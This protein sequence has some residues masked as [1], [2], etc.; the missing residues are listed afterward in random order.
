MEATL[1]GDI[2]KGGQRNP[3]ALRYP[4]SDHARAFFKRSGR[5]TWSS[6]NF[7]APHCSSNGQVRRPPQRVTRSRSSSFRF[8]EQLRNESGRRYL[9]I[10][11]Q[12]MFELNPDQMKEVVQ[13]PSLAK[14]LDLMRAGMM[15]VPANLVEDRIRERYFSS[16]Q[17][18]PC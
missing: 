16:P 9:R 14:A 10:L 13:Y 18:L 4:A 11:G 6:S 17:P 8:I 15:H 5:N 1:I 3:S 2:V 12:T 7:G